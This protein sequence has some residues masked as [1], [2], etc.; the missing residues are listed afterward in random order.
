M[1]K[2]TKIWINFM[3]FFQ[4]CCHQMPERSFFIKGY[5]M[6]VC[7][8]CVGVF[9]SSAIAIFVFFKKRISI[10][11]SILMS[12][13][14]LIDWLLQFFKIKQSNNVRRLITGLLGGFG[15]T[16]LNLKFLK[17]LLNKSKIN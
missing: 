5:Q 6:P 14:M 2:K 11:T 16:I 15:W 4:P 3:N 1:D 8:R 13:I 10:I 9:I 7:A 17:W 12:F